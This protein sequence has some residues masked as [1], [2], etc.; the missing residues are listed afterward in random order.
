MRALHIFL[1]FTALACASAT[2]AQGVQ[3]GQIAAMGEREGTVTLKL[4]DGSTR[5]YRLKDGLVFNAVQVGDIIRFTT[6]QENGQPVLSK[7]EK[8]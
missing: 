8:Q 6:D 1:L 5:E 7:I 4:K 3:E 2:L